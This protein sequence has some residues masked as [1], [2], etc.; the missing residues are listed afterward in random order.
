VVGGS[1]GG[2][3]VVGSGTAVAVGGAM[4]PVPLHTEHANLGIERAFGATGS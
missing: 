2:G 3:A 4:R 1:G